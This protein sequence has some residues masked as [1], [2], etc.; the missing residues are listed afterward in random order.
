[1]CDSLAKKDF[2]K[3]GLLAI[4][5]YEEM[6]SSSGG[7]CYPRFLRMALEKAMVSGLLKLS[8]KEIE[9]MATKAKGKYCNWGSYA[10]YSSSALKT[11]DLFKT[12]FYKNR[13]SGEIVSDHELIHTV[14]AMDNLAEFYYIGSHENHE[15]AVEHQKKVRWTPADGCFLDLA[16]I[17]Y[18]T[19]N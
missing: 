14:E 6:V 19:Y 16:H 12:S 11:G 3:V 2:N 8:R 1:M 18:L 9:E 17:K 4:V 13:K 15:A 7:N 10:S 5:Y